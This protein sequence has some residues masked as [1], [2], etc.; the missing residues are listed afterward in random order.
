MA[1]HEHEPKPKANAHPQV[2]AKPASANAARSSAAALP[3][4]KRGPAPVSTAGYSPETLAFGKIAPEL[5]QAAFRPDLAAPPTSSQA[6]PVQAR[7]AT[8]PVAPRE[9]SSPDASGQP[10]EVVQASLLGGIVG[11]VVGG[12]GGMLVG[13]PLGAIAGAAGGAALGH[14]LTSDEDEEPPT[15]RVSNRISDPP[16][17]WTSAYDVQVNATTIDLTI[18]VRLD[19]QAGVSEDDVA[20][21]QTRART[22]FR[23]KFDNQ[24]V[25]T[26]GETDFALRTDVEFVDSGEHAVVRLHAGN[27]RSNL[28]NWSV[29]RPAETFAHELGHQL[30]LLDEYIDAGAPNRATGT[31]PGVHTDHSMMGNIHAEG[32]DDAELKQRHGET[33]AGHVGAAVDREFTVRRR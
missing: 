19:P 10:G 3:A 25:F 14:A 31:S 23:A 15:V 6:Q 8:T 11:G 13:G 28:S 12:V 29:E 33:I 5:S 30:G 22:A 1:S 26:D 17:G 9:A 27:G 7:A 16:Y 18:R 2:Q 24:F 20:D 21:V 4:R 32:R